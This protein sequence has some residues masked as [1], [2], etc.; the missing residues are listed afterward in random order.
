M[1]ISVVGPLEW[2]SQNDPDYVVEEWASRPGP[3][4]KRVLT[5]ACECAKVAGYV[6]RD[7]TRRLVL[8]SR[9][10]ATRTI[11]LAFP[12][13]GDAGVMPKDRIVPQRFVTVYE[14]LAIGA[15]YFNPVKA[16]ASHD[17]QNTLIQCP[18]H[19]PLD[20]PKSVLDE[21]LQNRG[22]RINRPPR[23]QE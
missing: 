13:G 12:R 10:D 6:W 14:P 21:A 19:G 17:E 1:R 23:S 5:I 15:P 2:S 18:D 9:M 16:K 11:R 4:S 22:R 8:E 3:N 20:L 7:H